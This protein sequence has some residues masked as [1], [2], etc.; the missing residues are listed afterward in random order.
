M[1]TNKLSEITDGI[2]FIN[3]KQRKDRYDH[4]MNEFTKYIAFFANVG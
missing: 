1:N 4:I 2:I 3:L